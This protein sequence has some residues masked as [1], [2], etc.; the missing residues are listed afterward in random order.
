[1][2]TTQSPAERVRS[3][4][5]QI[6][7]ANRNYHEL[8]APTIDDLTYDALLEELRELEAAHPELASETSPTQRVGG[9]PS[10]DF[11]PYRHDVP[12]LSLANAFD[13]ESLRAFD[14]RVAK[15]AGAAPS[16]VCEL[17]ID[18]LAMSLRYE[19]GRLRSA[20]TRGDGSVG[21][22]VTANVRAIVGDPAAAARGVLRT[23]STCAAK[24]I[25]RRRHSPSS[26]RRVRPPDSRS[27]RRRA[28]PRR[29]GYVRRIRA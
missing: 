8:D 3:L 11:A 13:E 29:A 23:R 20:G 12:M 15:L 27:S 26:M 21:E 7:E 18:G 10:T 4:R 22:D 1:M 5:E 16:Y 9:A 28:T 19:G 24:C 17:K 14:G 6:A 2:A 25:S